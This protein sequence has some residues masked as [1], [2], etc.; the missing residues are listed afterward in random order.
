MSGHNPAPSPF[1]EALP[2]IVRGALGDV[3]AWVRRLH[4]DGAAADPQATLDAEREFVRS[5]EALY[6][7]LRRRLEDLDGPVSG[8]PDGELDTLASQL[9]AGLRGG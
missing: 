2:G 8:R 9:A 1:E 7:Y 5:M 3:D 6:A 4:A